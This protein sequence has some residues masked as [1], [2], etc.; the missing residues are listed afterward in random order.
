MKIDLRPGRYVVAVS[1]G[2]DSVV[3]LH[4]LAQQPGLKLTVAHFDHGIRED[5]AEDRKH[6]RALAKHYGLPFV[7]HAGN[8]GPGTSEASAREARYKFLHHVRRASGAE[9]VITAHHRDDVLETIIL[10]LLRGTGRRGLSSL[11]STDIVK[12]PL[13]HVPKNELLRYANSEGLRWREDSTNVDERYLR[14]Y[15]RKNI[16]PRFAE[17]DREAFYILGRWAEKTNRE[18]TAQV[19]NYLHVQ[20]SRT[21]LDRHSF[22]MLPHVVAREVMAEWL[23]QNTGAEISRMMLER[24]VA[25]AKSGKVGSKVDIDKGHW[26]EISRTYLALKPRER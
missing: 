17:R 23:L 19:V 11:K 13:L 6:V 22:I 9:A 26:L 7:Y 5:S 12:R 18:I 1:G 15:I 14:N 24:L 2:V 20:P 4:A 25:A 21:K 10:N 3:L 16:L 8:L